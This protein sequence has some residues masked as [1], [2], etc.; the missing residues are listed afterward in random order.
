MYP[1]ILN[2]PRIGEMWPEQGGIYAGVVVDAD[3]NDAYL[4]FYGSLLTTLTWCKSKSWA[5][6]VSDSLIFRLATKQEH[7]VLGGNL[8]HIIGRGLFW[9]SNHNVHD[10]LFCFVTNFENGDQ[11]CA[12]KTCAEA[13]PLAVR[14]VPVRGGPASVKGSLCQRCVHAST[15]SLVWAGEAKAFCLANPDVTKKCDAVR[16]N[17]G[18]CGQSGRLF[19][20]KVQASAQ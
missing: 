15:V 12:L 16:G 11:H 18:A 14:T 6:S 10:G 8:G 13:S 7:R 19:L 4:I 20:A 2:P 5:G 1:T 9:T 17:D 3:G